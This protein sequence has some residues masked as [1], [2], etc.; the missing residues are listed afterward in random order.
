MYTLHTDLYKVIFGGTIKHTHRYIKIKFLKCS[1]LFEKWN[2]GRDKGGEEREPCRAL[3]GQFYSRL[4]GPEGVHTCRL[5]ELLLITGEQSGDV[6]GASPL[7]P[8]GP[9]PRL[10]GIVMM[11]YN[12]SLYPFREMTP[13][14]NYENSI[15]RKW[16]TWSHSDP[17]FFYY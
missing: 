13:N 6:P 14:A 4:A 8:Q 2:R 12:F 7:P 11:C 5:N 15:V 3:G 9:P 10:L 16:K 1:K 17:L